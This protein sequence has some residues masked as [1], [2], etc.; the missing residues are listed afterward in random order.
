M[1]PCFSA[2]LSNLV[3]DF[4]ERDKVEVGLDR[5]SVDLFSGAV[6]NEGPDRALAWLRCEQVSAKQVLLGLSLEDDA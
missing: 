5:E 1:N 2:V 3:L 6:D 4:L